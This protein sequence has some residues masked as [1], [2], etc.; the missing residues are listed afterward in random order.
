MILILSGRIRTAE[1]IAEMLRYA[2][3]ICYCTTYAASL[4]EIA[5]QYKAV[6]AVEPHTEPCLDAYMRS[7]H[8]AAPRALLYSISGSIG[9]R[10]AFFIREYP[11]HVSPSHLLRDMTEDAR[12]LGTVA[13]GSYCAVGI[14]ASCN[15]KYAT[16]YDDR[17]PF[18]RTELMILRCLL[19][20]SPRPL[21]A[22][23]LL[24]Y[25]F[26][27]ARQPQVSAVRT[28]VSVINRRF[29]DMYGENLICMSE[30]GYCLVQTSR[31][32]IYASD[33]A[34]HF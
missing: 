10:S 26:K 19:A 9:G 16:I 32:A 34:A 31:L 6:L 8:E 3:V 20:S 28:H 22:D 33:R 29:R 14:D 7:I 15:R 13:P 5:P 11:R 25:A 23:E 1:A 18:T 17:L 24:K 12:R 4:G 2:G 27:R 30:H 21:S